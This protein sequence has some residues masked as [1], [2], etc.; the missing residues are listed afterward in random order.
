MY[1]FRTYNKTIGICGQSENTFLI[2]TCLSLCC[3]VSVS[4]SDV[5]LGFSDVILL[6]HPGEDGGSTQCS[7]VDSYSVHLVH[8]SGENQRGERARREARS[9]LSFFDFLVVY[10]HWYAFMIRVS[11]IKALLEKC[12]I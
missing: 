9:I 12:H 8:S 2:S 10:L 5:L 7:G 3:F 6:R 4:T 11:T 1:Y